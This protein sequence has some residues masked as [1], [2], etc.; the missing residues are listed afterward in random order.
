MTEEDDEALGVLLT[1]RGE[2]KFAELLQRMVKAKG[3]HFDMV[4]LKPAISPYGVKYDSTLKF[5]VALLEDIMM[6]YNEA[7]EVRMYEDRPKH[8]RSFREFFEGLNHRLTSD[9]RGSRRPFLAEIVQVTEGEST[10]DP[11]LEVAEVQKMVNV[12][13]KA[14]LNGDVPAGTPPYKLNRSVL[15]TGYL[16]PPA[17]TQRLKR[18]MQTSIPLP[19]NQIK[20][21]ANNI[22]ISPR[23]AP[24]HILQRAGGL[25]AK[26]R[27]RVTGSGQH[28]DRIWALRVEPASPGVQVY[29]NN[30]PAYIVMAS[31][32]FAKPIEASRIQKWLPMNEQFEFDTSVGERA[33]LRIDEEQ[34]EGGDEGREE[35]YIPID[36]GPRKHARDEDFPP[37]GPSRA[38]PR[39]QR[40]A[41]NNNQAWSANRNG[42]IG[43][44]A[45]RGNRNASRGDRRRG[46]GDRS[47][48]ARGGR[49]AYRSL[50]AN[51][52]QTYSSSAMEY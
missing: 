42:S 30:R 50:D 13:N 52:G 19:E 51:V 32:Q 43:F 47:G 31:T 45:Q 6:T 14:V 17:E 4:C 28:E 26:V 49:G 20:W 44:A 16:T 36:D 34:V 24:P 38:M 3:L 9:P 46:G 41:A 1:G 2:A 40:S 23:P 8:T 5:K 48:R 35:D 29:T 27:W 15:F 7:T 25:G 10:M 22:M 21:L 11:V 37:L 12:H 39:A 18:F 33:S